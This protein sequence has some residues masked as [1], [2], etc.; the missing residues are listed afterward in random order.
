MKALHESVRH[1]IEKKNDQYES[2]TNK[3]YKCFFFPTK[4]LGLSAYAQWEVSDP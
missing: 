1:H 3:G 4:W 2:K